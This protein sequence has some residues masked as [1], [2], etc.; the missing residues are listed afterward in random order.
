MD[1]DLETMRERYL[2]LSAELVEAAVD[3]HD[4]VL[5]ELRPP[6][7]DGSDEKELRKRL[8]Q[9][10]QRIASICDRIRLFERQAGGRIGVP[11]LLGGDVPNPLR[12]ALTVLATR[13]ISHGVTAETRT[14]A[15]LADVCAGNVPKDNLIVVE[16]CR[17]NG[18]LRPH[19]HFDYGRTIGELADLTLT[20]A[21]FR[22]LLA[23]EPDAEMALLAELR[24][25]GNRRIVR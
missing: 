10:N 13:V 9:C 20:E 2:D 4:G 12:I 3:R 11:A 14:V 24:R 1:A 5:N 23:L 8:A 15:F 25:N 16:S 17:S 6:R 7:F 19:I 22:R 21:S 18:V